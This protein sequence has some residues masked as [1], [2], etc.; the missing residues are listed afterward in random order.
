MKHH[1]KGLNLIIY[2][3]NNKFGP[4]C[5]KYPEKIQYEFPRVGLITEPELVAGRI[6]RLNFVVAL[7]RG[8]YRKHLSI[9]VS[10]HEI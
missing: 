5:Y 6:Y 4:Q 2:H 9:S 8:S 7:F 10:K 3:E 1:P